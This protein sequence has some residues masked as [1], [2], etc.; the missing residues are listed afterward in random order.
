MIDDKDSKRMEKEV[1]AALSEIMDLL[2]VMAARLQEVREAVDKY[3]P[4]EY[5][6]YCGTDNSDFKEELLDILKV[7]GGE[8]DIRNGS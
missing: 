2:G 1:D 6:I 5:C 7:K 4:D 3:K 8:G